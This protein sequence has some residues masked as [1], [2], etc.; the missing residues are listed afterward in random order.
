MSSKF[1]FS[2]LKLV[3]VSSP[4]SVFAL[5]WLHF[6]IPDVDISNSFTS[7]ELSIHPLLFIP[8]LLGIP[9]AGSNPPGHLQFSHPLWFNGLLDTSIINIFVYPTALGTVVLLFYIGLIG[10]R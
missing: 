10:L 1:L 2:L 5:D 8:I 7:L 3:F 4:S 6:H 9:K